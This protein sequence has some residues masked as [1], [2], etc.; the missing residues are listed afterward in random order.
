M[1]AAQPQR[2]ALEVVLEEFM[3]SSGRLLVCFS[4][5]VSLINMAFA[6]EWNGI[7]PLKSTR[8]DVE[9]KFGK[10][11]ND[12]YHYRGQF[13]SFEYANFPCAHESPPG[14]PQAPPGW[15]VPP[16]TVTAIRVAF[17][18]R[19]I[20]VST[21]PFDLVSFEKVRGDSDLPQHFYYTNKA[22]GFAIEFFDFGDKQGEIAESFIYTPTIEEEKQFRCKQ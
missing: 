1:R 19:P 3:K 17:R 10:S 7:I 16:N 21:L 18:N 11:K 8:A 15:D 14:W 13:V 2:Y 4:L 20:A 5:I 22:E 12:L 9:R 6:K